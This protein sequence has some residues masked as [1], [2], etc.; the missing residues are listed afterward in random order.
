MPSDRYTALLSVHGIGRHDAS[1]NAGALLEALEN[2]ARRHDG[3]RIFLAE[4]RT[5]L[6]PHRDDPSQPDVAAIEVLQL[7]RGRRKRISRSRRARVYEVNWSPETRNAVSASAMLVWLGKLFVTTILP[8]ADNWLRSPR[9]RRAQL[10]ASMPANETNGERH[11]RTMLASSYRKFRGTAGQEYRRSEGIKTHA[12]FQ[13]FRDFAAER[14]RRAYPTERLL[15]AATRW[16]STNLPA[17]DSIKR[18]SNIAASIFLTTVA[19]LAA[20]LLLLVR[21]PLDSISVGYLTILSI[22]TITILIVVA[23]LHY[24]MSRIISDIRYWSAISENERYSEIRRAVLTK[25]VRMITHIVE[26]PDCER[27]VIVSHSLG[28]T[29]AYDALREIGRQNRARTTLTDRKQVP[30]EK[31]R[32]FITLGSPIDKIACLFEPDGGK[33]F[34]EAE[35][36]EDVR[37]DLSQAP[38]FIGGNPAIRWTNFWDRADPISDPLFTPLGS[39]ASG[40]T[41]LT[42]PI[43]NIEVANTSGFDPVGSHVTYLENPDITRTIFSSAFFDEGGILLPKAEPDGRYDKSRKW[44]KVY[45]KAFQFSAPLIFGSIVIALIWPSLAILPQIGVTLLAVLVVSTLFIAL[46]SKITKFCRAFTGLW[47]AR[48]IFRF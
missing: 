24:A 1:R 31:L 42:A 21:Y 14:T 33:T 20:D 41:F 27:L 8:R 35:L 36:N 12:S 38:F 23:G 26:D 40:D 2:E 4:T 30:I 37:G 46:G 32:D 15:A 17:E 25:T 34:R 10:H 29:I 6:E 28:T 44:T 43:F 13:Q 5:I 19:L 45:L 16:A 47:S 22:P 7:R 9:L 11:A 18:I 39:K 48:R 3:D